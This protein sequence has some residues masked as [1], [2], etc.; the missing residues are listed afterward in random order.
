M[1]KG[2]CGIDVY[3]M[4]SSN[5]Y[6]SIKQRKMLPSNERISRFQVYITHETYGS[7]YVK[8]YLSLYCEHFQIHKGKRNEKLW[9]KNYS[10][11]MKISM[12]VL[13]TKEYAE[14]SLV[15]FEVMIWNHYN[16]KRMNLKTK[17]WMIH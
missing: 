7:L 1:F 2:I 12:S 10:A 16:A 8:T 6:L 3:V 5:V 13:L 15:K 9:M 17:I 11:M 4:I 14:F